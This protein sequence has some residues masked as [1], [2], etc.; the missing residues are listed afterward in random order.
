MPRGTTGAVVWTGEEPRTERSGFATRAVSGFWT[1]RGERLFPPGFAAARRAILPPF[2]E[3]APMSHRAFRDRAHFP[4]LDGLRGICVLLV[5]SV[6]LY[7]HK[8][9]W[10]WLAGAKG[11]VVFFVLSGFLITT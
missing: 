10:A 1:R 8:A 2:T 3:E 6:H 9:Y 4:E 7:A 5:I 11:V